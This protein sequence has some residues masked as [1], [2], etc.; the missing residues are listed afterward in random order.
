[1]SGA[2]S[3]MTIA[4]KEILVSFRTKVP[5]NIE[6]KYLLDW[7]SYELGATG[8]IRND[9]PLY[10]VETEAVPFSAIVR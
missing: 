8:S 2:E 5:E 3:K 4:G 9:N 1:M 10:E 7:L 6:L